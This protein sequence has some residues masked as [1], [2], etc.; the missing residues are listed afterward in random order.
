MSLD[1]F[2]IARKWPAQHPDRIKRMRALLEKQV[3]EGRST[4]G[5]PQSND[6]PVRIDKP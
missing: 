5:A 2:A 6:V 4:P 3:A 1:R